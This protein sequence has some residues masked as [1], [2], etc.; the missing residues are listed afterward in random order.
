MD[1]ADLRRDAEE[2]SGEMYKRLVDHILV[3]EEQIR[4]GRSKIALLERKNRE[5]RGRLGTIKV[6]SPENG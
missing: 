5:L 1:M 3:L 4:I 6:G 2:S